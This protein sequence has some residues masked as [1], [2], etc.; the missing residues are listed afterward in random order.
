M[1]LKRKPMINHL[2]SSLFICKW[3]I[4]HSFHFHLVHPMAAVV[5]CVCYC[6]TTFDVRTNNVVPWPSQ[7]G[8]K[9]SRQSDGRV[10]ESYNVFIWWTP[11]DG[12][13]IKWTSVLFLSGDFGEI[14]INA[15]KCSHIFRKFSSPNCMLSRERRLWIDQLRFVCLYLGVQQPFIMKWRFWHCFNLDGVVVVLVVKDYWLVIWGLLVEFT[16]V[17][18]WFIVL[19]NVRPF[20]DYCYTWLMVYHPIKSISKS[21][22]THIYWNVSYSG[23]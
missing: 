9:A 12:L 16:L 18:N 20:W 23:N 8:L 2:H 22:D 6:R 10:K 21:I 15:Q 14:C 3:L 5:L 13:H 11:E 7:G 19:P 17:I 1:A 4:F